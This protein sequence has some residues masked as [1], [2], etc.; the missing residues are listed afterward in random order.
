MVH[1]ILESTKK[2]RMKLPV[3]AAFGVWSPEIIP[4]GNDGIS[5][6]NLSFE[7]VVHYTSRV[8]TLESYS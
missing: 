3:K 4:G 1:A 8:D 7:S 5:Y 6:G 2:Q